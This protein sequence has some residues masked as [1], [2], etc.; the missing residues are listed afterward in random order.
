MDG[1]PGTADVEPKDA[2]SKRQVCHNVHQLTANTTTANIS[3]NVPNERNLYTTDVPLSQPT[4]FNY[5]L[6]RATENSYAGNALK[7]LHIYMLYL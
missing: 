6:Q 4:N 7:Y 2:D 5:S 1:D 3:Q